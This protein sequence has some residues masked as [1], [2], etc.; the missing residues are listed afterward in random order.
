MEQTLTRD[1]GRTI[2]Y[3]P[4][5]NR[6]WKHYQEQGQIT[7]EGI[8][9]DIIDSWENSRKLGIN[10]FQNRINEIVRQNELDDRL[11]KNKELLSF[12]TP[13][14]ER[15]TDVLNESKTMFSIADHQGTILNSVGERNVLKQAE[16][17][18]IFTG[19]TWTE[20]SA[21][22]NAVGLA[23]KTKQYAQVLFSEHYC[24]KN[25]DWFCVASPILYPFT[26]ELLGVINIAGRSVERNQEKVNFIISEANQLSRSI[27]Q[28]FFKHAL[29][30]NLFLNT[31]LE[32]VE[33]AVFIVNSGKSIV[34]KNVAARSH[35]VLSEVQALNGIP[36]LDR[37]C[38]VC[39]TKRSF[40]FE[41]RS[42]WYI[43]I[44]KQYICSVYPVTFP[45]GKSRGCDL[46]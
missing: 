8:R 10:P 20:Q 28:Y 45:R 38:R 12:A 30:N 18:N 29:R 9:H 25:H 3:N 19:G 1:I 4:S 22:T 42:I 24:E 17:I 5:V 16:T 21:G 34:E 36:K 41:R 27:H 39:F 31:A 7:G 26:N 23:L 6:V 43:K 44:N 11:E 32:G 2:E 14:I 33:D 15:L 35:S 40:H 37:L 13:Q 46:F